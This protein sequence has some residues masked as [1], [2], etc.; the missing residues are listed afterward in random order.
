VALDGDGTTIGLASAG[1]ARD[2]DAPTPWELYSINVVA[3]VQGSGVADDLV[4]VVAGD[5][6]TVVWVLSQNSRAQA[7]YRRHGFTVEGATRVH[8]ASGAGELRMVR[9]SPR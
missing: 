9:R 8:E 1:A 3:Q 7:F 5:N 6:D 2:E 4:R